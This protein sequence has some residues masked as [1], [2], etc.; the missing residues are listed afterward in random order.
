M[1]LATQGNPTVLLPLYAP[2]SFLTQVDGFGRELRALRGS[3]VSQ[4]CR[5]RFLGYLESQRRRVLERRGTGRGRLEGR[6]EKWASHM[7][8]LGFEACELLATGELTFADAYARGRLLQGDQAWGRV[9]RRGPAR[10]EELEQRAAAIDAS[11][12]R[13][14]P[15]LEQVQ[16]WMHSVY[17][18][19]L[20]APAAASH[21]VR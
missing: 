5:P 14:E 17:Q 21:P 4:A 2:E 1:R 13:A 11:P 7:V 10:A 8:R 6:W 18:R 19:L 12:L 9:A 15:D 16:T 20:L 3:I